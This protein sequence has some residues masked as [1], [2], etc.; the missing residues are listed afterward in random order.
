MI[1][2]EEMQSTLILTKIIIAYPGEDYIDEFYNVFSSQNELQYH[3]RLRDPNFDDFNYI[4]FYYQTSEG[5][6][7]QF[8]IRKSSIKGEL[9]KWQVYH[10]NKHL[11]TFECDDRSNFVKIFEKQLKI[12]LEKN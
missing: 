12:E 3:L 5:I 4:D 11:F 7:L 2:S 6:E 10:L 8:I 9:F 1:N